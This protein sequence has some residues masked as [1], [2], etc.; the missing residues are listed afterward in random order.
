MTDLFL[1]AAASCNKPGLPGIISSGPLPQTCADR[2]TVT[3][4]FNIVFIIVGAM[5]LL[6]MVIA[7]A[8]YALSKGEPENIQKAKNELKYSAIGLIIVSLA[9]ALVNLVIDRLK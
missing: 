8:R 6:V 9:A 5:A 3:V 4:V 2:S 1:A 7:G